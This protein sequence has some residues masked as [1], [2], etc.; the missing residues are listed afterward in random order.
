[1]ASL[2]SVARLIINAYD[3]KPED[4]APEDLASQQTVS[5]IYIALL[6]RK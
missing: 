1:M 5:R 2:V 3:V 6:A 4:C